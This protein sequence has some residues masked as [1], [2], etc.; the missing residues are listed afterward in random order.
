MARSESSSPSGP[1]ESAVTSSSRSSAS[2]TT[3]DLTSIRAFAILLRVGGG[4]MGDNGWR[5]SGISPNLPWSEASHLT[6]L[7]RCDALARHAHRKLSDADGRAQDL[8]RLLNESASCYESAEHAA[9]LKFHHTWGPRHLSLAIYTGLKTAG[10]VLGLGGDV[11]GERRAAMINEGIAQTIE[12]VDAALPGDYEDAISVIAAAAK[13]YSSRGDAIAHMAA[14][15]TS[16]APARAGTSITD[17]ASITSDLYDHPDDASHVHVQRTVDA[18]GEGHWVVAIPGTYDWTLDSRHGLD[19]TGNLLAAAGKPTAV[20][21][22]ILSALRQAQKAEGVLGKGEPVMLVGH[23]QG[24]MLAHNI[25]RDKKAQKEFNIK[26]ITTFGSP[27]GRSKP[28]VTADGTQVQ[29]LNI[30]MKSDLVPQLDG[31]ATGDGDP[32]RS[33]VVINDR[34]AMVGTKGEY[35]AIGP[36]DVLQYSWDYEAVRPKESA[37]QSYEQSTQTYFGEDT[38]TYRFDLSRPNPKG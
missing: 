26:N 35:E 8:A 10:T 15:P 23:S 12:H 5:L 32:G 19:A 21:P 30:E 3:A 7:R 36:H 18:S 33:R 2:A 28:G 34:H 29:E 20:T 6:L 25:A 22:G 38:R 31:A 16:H 4:D 37:I 11:P 27:V 14:D 9:T 17:I 1:S 24:G 13:H